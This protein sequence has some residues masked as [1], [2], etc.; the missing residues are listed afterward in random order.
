NPK[1]VV[2]HGRDLRPSCRD[3]YVAGEQH[4]GLG[5][6]ELALR[7]VEELPWQTAQC[8]VRVVAERQQ[9]AQRL[10]V[11]VPHTLEQRPPDVVVEDEPPQELA[12]QLE[13]RGLQK[14]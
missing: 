8:R 10:A 14:R 4:S 2:A 5:S 13:R 11:A 9:Q 7:R 6:E 1:L 12:H 3:W